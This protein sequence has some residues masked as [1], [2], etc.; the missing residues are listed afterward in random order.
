[1]KMLDYISTEDEDVGLYLNWWW[2]CWI[3][4]WMM[5][6][7]DY[8]STD[9]EDVGFLNG[10]WRCWIIMKDELYDNDKYK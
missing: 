4:Q 1:M 8:I 2:R 3:S 7:L 6:M 5:K 10:W 9:D